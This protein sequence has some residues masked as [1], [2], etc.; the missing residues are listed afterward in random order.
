MT[1]RNLSAV[2]GFS[3]LSAETRRV[4]QWLADDAAGSDHVLTTGELTAYVAA[5]PTMGTRSRAAAEWLASAF[6]SDS[7]LEIATPRLPRETRTTVRPAPGSA[8]I[9]L[10]RGC[11]T[12]RRV[13][14]SAV[15][16]LLLHSNLQAHADRA[17]SFSPFLSHVAPEL[18]R[19]DLTLANLE[20]PTARGLT[21]QTTTS[22][23]RTVSRSIEVD[24]YYDGTA[25]TG[26]PRFNSHPDWLG[27]IR[28]AGIDVVTTSN[29]HALDRG[30]NGVDMTLDAL[31]AAGLAHAG[32]ARYEAGRAEMPASSRYTI[33][34]VNGVRVAVFGYTFSTNGIPDRYGQ[35]SALSAEQAAA[36]VRA[37]RASGAADVIVV[38]PHW[39]V[40]YQ[41]LHTAEQ[42]RIAHA[43]LDAGADAVI[44]SHP[45]VLQPLERYTTADGRDTVVAYS[46]G[47]FVAAQ[48][49]SERRESAILHLTFTQPPGGRARVA[50]V[51]YVPVQIDRRFSPEADALVDLPILIDT[52]DGD[53]RARENVVNALGTG[54]GN[55][56]APGAALGPSCGDS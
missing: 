2:S 11:E 1:Q 5:H 9:T 23:G 6:A 14:L 50:S 49:G 40:E 12:G 39:G 4:A 16:D 38:A 3:G 32:S 55:A 35:V 10:E 34:N 47:N 31:D 28:A 29:N 27:S 33:R 53:P 24:G 41:H 46:L 13:T 42:R 7:S 36:D 20:T 19:A 15:G 30:S 43:V 26:Y 56:I 51:Q 52:Q 44:G 54:G 25:Y 17:G 22:G 48:I 18:S 8:P 37:L 21:Q 45:H